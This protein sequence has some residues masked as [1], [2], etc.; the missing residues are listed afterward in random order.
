MSDPRWPADDPWYRF[1]PR[2]RVTGYLSLVAFGI[3][4]VVSGMMLLDDRTSTRMTVF[5]VLF[6]L[7]AVAGIVR[8]ANGLKT[9][10]RRS[11]R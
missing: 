7:V 1:T 4:L 3:C 8:S 9:L 5:Y 10:R 2:N 11:D 6:A